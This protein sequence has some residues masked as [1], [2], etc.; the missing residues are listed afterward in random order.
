MKAVHYVR[1]F[2]LVGAIVCAGAMAQTMEE[3][4]SRVSRP[5]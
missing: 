2:A 1:V 5:P 3:G 4:A